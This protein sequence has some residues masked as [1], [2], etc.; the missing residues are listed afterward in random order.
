[1]GRIFLRLLQILI[2]I[3][4]AFAYVFGAIVFIVVGASW[5]LSIFDR[6]RE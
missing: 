6:N 2:T 3:I 4:I 5:V 1:M